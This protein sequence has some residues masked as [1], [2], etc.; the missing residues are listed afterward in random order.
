MSE[1]M[2]SRAPFT[3]CRIP[4][5]T[6]DL[7]RSSTP[8]RPVMV[9]TRLVWCA[10]QAIEGGRCCETHDELD[11]A[12]SMWDRRDDGALICWVDGGKAIEDRT[13]GE[14]GRGGSMRWLSCGVWGH[15]IWQVLVGTGIGLDW[16]HDN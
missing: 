16:G 15:R 2:T 10:G 4:E 14:T 5:W 6:E 12:D 3:Q 13:C 1:Q 8:E 9:R 11:S 7:A